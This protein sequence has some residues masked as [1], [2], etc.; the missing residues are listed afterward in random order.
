M[1]LFVRIIDNLF[2]FV[3]KYDTLYKI[4]MMGGKL[5]KDFLTY[6]AIFEII[7]DVYDALIGAGLVFGA[8]KWRK[9]LLTTTAFYWG[10]VLGCISGLLICYFLNVD[11]IIFIITTVLGA[12]ILPILTYRI[13]A[14]NRFI[15]GFLITMKLL[16]MLTTHLVSNNNIELS[17]AIISPLIGA[18]VLGIIFMLLRQLSVL[19]F[20]LGCVFLGASQLAPTIVKY[21]N[22]I[23]FGITHDVSLLFD[24][25]SFIFAL[26]KIELTDG[27]TLIIMIILICIGLPIQ[28]KDIKKQGYTYDTPIIVFET[29]DPNMHGKIIS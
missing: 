13:P 8:L 23:Q 16:Y 5:M 4:L 7:T 27:L 19:P 1:L 9:N 3:K 29:N 11:F 15:L 22:Q 6:I 17:T 28:L 20:A 18:T 2:T 14:V 24:P 25:V 12:I 10:V 26:F 21:I